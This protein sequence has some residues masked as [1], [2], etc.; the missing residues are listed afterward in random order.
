GADSSISG[1]STDNPIQIGGD[2]Y[3]GAGSVLGGNLFVQGAL[4]GDGGTISPGNSIGVQSYGS[5]AEFTGAYTAEVNAAG[6]SDLIII[7]SGDFDLSGIDLF[8]RQEDGT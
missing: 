8:V 7:R 1:G 2:A 5:S 3:A 4:G 6:N